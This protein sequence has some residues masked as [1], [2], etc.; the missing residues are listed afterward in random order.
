MQEPLHETYKEIAEDFAVGYTLKTDVWQET[1]D[2]YEAPIK[3]DQYVEILPELVEKAQELR[4]DCTHGSVSDLPYTH[5]VFDTV[6]DTST[7]DHTPKYEDVLKEYRR[8]LKDNGRLLLITWVTSKETYSEGKDLAGGEQYYFNE[9]DFLKT[10]KGHF[11]VESTET[12]RD[13]GTKKV[14]CYKCFKI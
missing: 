2:E 9:T 12:L 13:V 1:R 5:K 10:L 11:K 8:V 14:M 7:I 3:A 6:I 4:L